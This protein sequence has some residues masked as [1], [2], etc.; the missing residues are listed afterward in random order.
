MSNA[1][2]IPFGAALFVAAVTLSGEALANPKL[3]KQIERKTAKAMESYDFMEFEEAK[4]KLLAVVVAAEDASLR[5]PVVARAYVQLGVVYFSGL[6]DADSAREAFAQAVAIDPSVEI[7]LDYRTKELSALLKEAKAGGGGSSGGAADCDVEEMEHELLETAKT[8]TRQSVSALVAPDL[9]ADKVVLYY[10]AEGQDEFAKASMKKKGECQFVGAI[11]GDAVRGEF[12]HYYVAAEDSDG[13]SLARKGSSGSPNIIEIGTSIDSE[14][15]LSSSSGGS[16]G[17]GVEVGPSGPS[18]LFV[19]L[20]VG[21]GGGYVTGRTELE[22]SPVGCC[23]APALLHLFPEIG[24][25][26]TPQMSISAAL[27]LGFAIGANLEGHATMAPAGL[28]RVRYAL[29]ESGNGVEVSGALG[30]GF[31]R[32]TVKIRGAPAGMD[33]DTTATGPVLVG[34]G[35]GYRYGLSSSLKLV[36]E[37]HSI[38]GLTA[39]LKEVGSGSGSV[40][41]N[42]GVQFDA[43]LGILFNF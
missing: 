6:E 28:L 37:L 8:G 23:F 43:N 29:N 24:Y 36:A 26:L 39:G 19:S 27:R 21:G 31:I 17:G 14:D 22:D 2:L 34:A 25:K 18:K 38:A 13:K 9:G 16:I 41:P 11:P 33:T 42:F 12:V 10:R 30:G 35:L 7:T 40:R 15:P 1:R 4:E 32:N 20:A 3:K 5:D